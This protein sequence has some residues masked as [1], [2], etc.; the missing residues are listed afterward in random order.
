VQ[1]PLPIYVAGHTEAMFR[2][3]ARHGYRVLSSGRV[4]G[5]ALLAEQYQIIKDAY[6]AE[7]V[8]LATQRINP[9]SHDETGTAKGVGML[10]LEIGKRGDTA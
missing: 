8:S 4:G 6:R 5:A 9:A 1:K 3:A 2:T 7:G 10:D